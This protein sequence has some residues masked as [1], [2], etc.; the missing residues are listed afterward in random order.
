MIAV[1]SSEYFSNRCTGLMS[2][3]GKSHA[4]V[5]DEARVLLRARY[6]VSAGLGGRL[7]RCESAVGCRV[8]YALYGG[9]KAGIYNQKKIQKNQIGLVM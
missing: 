5:N 4:C 7:L 2:N 3:D 1:R 9:S 8:I 6:A